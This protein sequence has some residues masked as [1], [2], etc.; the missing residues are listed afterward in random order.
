MCATTARLLL[1]FFNLHGMSVLLSGGFY[2]LLVTSMHLQV[3]YNS[4]GCN[5]VLGFTALLGS[6]GLYILSN[7]TG[8][9]FFSFSPP[10]HF[11][12]TLVSILAF[13]IDIVFHSALTFLRASEN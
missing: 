13:Q 5:G 6:A 1:F 11:K 9:F 7:V 10:L 12:N 4:L 8:F 2:Y 3:N